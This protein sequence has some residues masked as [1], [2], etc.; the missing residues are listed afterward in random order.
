RAARQMHG[1]RDLWLVVGCTLVL[2]GIMLRVYPLGANDMYDYIFRAR[3]WV[4]SDS[5][6]LVVRP[7]PLSPHLR[8][9]HAV[10][11]WAASRHGPPWLYAR[12]RFTLA[13]VAGVLA[14]LVKV[15][16]LVV[17]P[18]LF[19]ACVRAM[20][21]SGKGAGQAGAETTA[22]RPQYSSR[23]FARGFSFGVSTVTLC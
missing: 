1:A 14:A 2:C 20:R 5:T 19:V 18:V 3:G 11:T 12:R 8:H 15:S 7:D 13:L 6:P 4:A 10:W 17:V 16:A 9:P 22:R 23:G 21:E